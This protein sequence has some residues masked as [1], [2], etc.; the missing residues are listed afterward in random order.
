[1]NRFFFFVPLRMEIPTYLLGEGLFCSGVSAFCIKTTR[2][3]K[4]H[5]RRLFQFFFSARVS[6]D[7]AWIFSRWS[8]LRHARRTR[9]EHAC[10]TSKKREKTTSR[11]SELF[12]PVS[13]FHA[14]VPY[15]RGRTHRSRIFR[16]RIKKKR[17]TAREGGAS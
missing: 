6:D 2:S 1:M 8:T 13:T 10:M 16:L 11:T 7:R 12:L 4:T 14:L 17:S 9:Q 5:R 3:V 15:G